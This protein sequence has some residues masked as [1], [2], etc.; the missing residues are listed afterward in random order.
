MSVASST[1]DEAQKALTNSLVK[2]RK[3][4]FSFNLNHLSVAFYRSIRYATM[5][6]TGCLTHRSH[7]HT[8][9]TIRHCL[10]CHRVFVFCAVKNVWR[11][12]RF[13]QCTTTESKRRNLS[14]VY[15]FRCAG[16]CLE[17]NILGVNRMNGFSTHFF[18]LFSLQQAASQTQTRLDRCVRFGRSHCPKSGELLGHRSIVSH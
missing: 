16:I 8:S 17:I 4:R 2:R 14:F 5:T 10:Q 13:G 18:S 1:T 15:T 12:D 7:T 6:P 9:M 3:R 11:I